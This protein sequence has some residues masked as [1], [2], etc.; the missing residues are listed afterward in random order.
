MIMAE[1]TG[2]KRSL[3]MP[4]SLKRRHSLTISEPLVGAERLWRGSRFWALDDD[5]NEDSGD[6]GTKQEDGDPGEESYNSEKEFMR[7]ATW[8]GFSLDDLIRAE[9]LLT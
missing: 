2:P 6:D 3:M 4:G 8:A 5:G 7:G 9:T 1:Q